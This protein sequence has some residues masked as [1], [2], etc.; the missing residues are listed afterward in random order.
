MFHERSRRGQSDNLCH[1]DGIESSMA[2]WSVEICCI[3]YL[4]QTLFS[5]NTTSSMYRTINF[6]T[7]NENKIGSM[8]ILIVNVTCLIQTDGR[9]DRIFFPEKKLDLRAQNGYSF[10][11]TR[12]LNGK[13]LRDGTSIELSMTQE[14]L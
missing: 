3:A 5:R 7:R 2:E 14:I 10:S 1:F 13:E 6:S 11:R 12:G 4:L 8:Y 9:Y